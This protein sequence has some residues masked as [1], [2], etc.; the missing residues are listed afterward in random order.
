[1]DCHFG[2]TQTNQNTAEADKNNQLLCSGVFIPFPALVILEAGGCC[3]R[4]GFIIFTFRVL[5]LLQE[6]SGKTGPYVARLV[7]AP[8]P[9]TARHHLHKALGYTQDFMGDLDTTPPMSSHLAFPSFLCP[10]LGT[11]L[12][13][14][15]PH[16]QD[17][18]SLGLQLQAKL[19][20]TKQ[21][22]R[23]GKTWQKL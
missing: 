15:I 23:A 7:P 4:F 11:P 5:C 20:T 19:F 9:P 21:N 18:H 14:F 10:S 3:P 2:W 12:L 22:H 13:R 8:L 17:I 6:M 1:M 16:T